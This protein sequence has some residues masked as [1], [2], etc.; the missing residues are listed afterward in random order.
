MLL[1]KSYNA[2][3]KS[4]Y[5][6]KKKKLLKLEVLSIFPASRDIIC[7]LQGDFFFVFIVIKPNLYIN[8]NV[9]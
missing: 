4:A 7:M 1:A 5:L 8:K 2:Q 3:A 6:K 9:Y